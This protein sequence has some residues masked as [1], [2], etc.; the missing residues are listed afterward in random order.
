M[1][2]MDWDGDMSDDFDYSY[3]SGEGDGD[4]DPEIWLE[5]QYFLA[6]QEENGQKKVELLQAFI[7]H[8][9]VNDPSHILWKYK[10][11]KQLCNVMLHG[12]YP[13]PTIL[14]SM[15]ALI[16]LLK[17]PSL[18]KQKVLK[19]VGRLI[20]LVIKGLHL[21]PEHLQDIQSLVGLIPAH[22]HDKLVFLCHRL[23]M[24]YFLE[25]DLLEQC[26]VEMGIIL[27]MHEEWKEKDSQVSYGSEGVE[28]LALQI[29]LHS[30]LN[31]VRQLKKLFAESKR[32]NAAVCNPL[33]LAIIHECGAKAFMLEKRWNDAYLNF[34]ASF[35]NYA[36]AGSPHK[37]TILQYVILS[38]MLNDAP[39][40]PFDAQE[41]RP[42][43]K[44][45]S[46]RHFIALLEAYQHNDV[47]RFESYLRSL[48]QEDIFFLRYIQQL[49]DNL[50]LNVLEKA[51][52]CFSACSFALL[53][54]LVDRQLDDIE[55]LLMRL[56]HERGC[57]F[58]MDVLR[59]CVTSCPP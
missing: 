31:N 53:A 38:N 14:E 10:A 1:D 33:T 28:V 41:V 12:L 36:D 54:N 6:K 57:A 4:E 39:V 56:I 42:Y 32:F 11:L 35:C 44:D 16:G 15:M 27:A 23:F 13:F 19:G 58:R 21:H 5:N 3:S 24:E 8:P 43:A 25:K 45:E 40:N 59:K 9:H 51:I 29:Q 7:E 48:P 26:Q 17:D 18:S 47:K 30:K 22:L 2:D 37:V 52:Q 46:I 50:H 34:F 49:R 55:A 20:K